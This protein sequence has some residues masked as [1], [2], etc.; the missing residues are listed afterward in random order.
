[1]GTDLDRAAALHRS[2]A[3][4]LAALGPA[5][6]P[7]P[8]GGGTD[9][10]QH[11]IAEQLRSLAARLAPGWWGAPLDAQTP[12]MPIGGLDH[13][14]YLRIGIA[15]PL[16]DARFPVLV[17]FL[18]TGHLAIDGDVRDQRVAG[19]LRATLLRLLAAVPQRRLA[20]R[21]VDGIETTRQGVLAPFQRLI[22][23][24]V[25]R[26]AATELTGLRA[27]LAEAEQWIRPAR[28]TVTRHHR[29]GRFMLL[30]IASLPESTDGGDLGR[31]D[32]LAQAGPEHGLHLVVAGWP[33][34]PLTPEQT[35]TELPRSTTVRLRNPH[36]LIGDPPGDAFTDPS[37]A[38]G[39]PGGLNAPAYLDAGPPQQLIDRVGAELVAAADA[40]V[41][42]PLAEL[43]PDPTTQLWTESAAEGLAAGAGFDGHRQVV[44]R[45]NDITPHWLVAGRPGSGVDGFVITVLYGLAVR[46]RPAELAVHLVDLSPGESFAS[47]LPTDADPSWLPHVDTA[48]AEADP[49]YALSVLRLLAAEVDRRT[50]LAGRNGTSKFTELATA[51]GIGR[52]L[53]VLKDPAPLLD[54]GTGTA[55]EA[56]ELLERIT[57]AGR[58]CG[59]H[60]LLA[61]SGDDG[62]GGRRGDADG[63]R[64]RESLLTQFPV[65]V[66]LPGGD[67][68]LEPNNDSAVGLPVGSAVV[69]TAG[70]LGGP[71][72]A[73]RGHERTVS[74]PDPY[75]DL[76]GLTRLRQQIW[77]RRDTE[78]RPPQIFAGY[79]QPDLASDAGYQQALAGP[80]GP[81]GPTGPTGPPSCLLGQAVEVPQRSAEFRFERAPGRHLAIFGSRDLTADLLAT[82]VLSL[83]AHHPPGS[84]RMLFVSLGEHDR[85]QLAAL[86]D[87][88]EGRQPTEVVDL[89]ILRTLGEETG[90]AYLIVAT[91]DV[92]ELGGPAAAR[93]R[94]LLDSGPARG[95]HLLSCWQQAAPF[96]AF[97]GPSP[98]LI[99]GL[100]LLDLPVTGVPGLADRLPQWRP[101]HQRGLLY[102]G[103]TD[104]HTVFVPF[105]RAAVPGAGRE[106]A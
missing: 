5:G 60:L 79:R 61:D 80:A 36:V 106:A 65:R 8:A 62:Q 30:L 68:L 74:F 40:G 78:T 76:P 18:G 105:R 25:L 23:G 50:W 56:A 16:D 87:L 53:G 45:F 71:R 73:I 96:T 64:H 67:W 85:A 10:S 82:A 24:G 66:A 48:G 46:H 52:I 98:E 90:P 51:A 72:G 35:R 9:T 14:G 22:D 102:D 63:W 88:I 101:R 7:A 4:T 69:N 59:V 29:Q 43:L 91:A 95:I 58:G 31:I 47:V 49:E 86:T 42:P 2:A 13:A 27:A 93:L 44:L 41:R 1:M 11:E 15:Q 99:A 17:P 94:N 6:R 34:P 97:L 37:A 32:R 39:R 77:S 81:T 28:P 100:V 12:A 3:A 70:G 89:D 92:L 33:P 54:P 104:R 75:A 21:T 19:L 83:A 84:A 57:R 55:A 20:V 38:P 26:P 103:Q